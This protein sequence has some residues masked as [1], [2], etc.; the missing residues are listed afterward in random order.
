[1]LIIANGE[2]MSRS[3]S[4]GQVHDKITESWVHLRP[5]K[6]NPVVSVGRRKDVR[7]AR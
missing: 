4:S 1:M 7:R 3:E 2:E 5:S 6:S